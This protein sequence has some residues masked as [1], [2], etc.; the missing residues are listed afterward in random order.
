MNNNRLILGDSIEILKNIPSQS[1]DLILSDIP[2]GIGIDDWDVLHNNT[3]SA[4]GGSS[5]AQSKAGAAFKSRGKPINGWSEADRRIPFEYYEW[6]RTWAPDWNRVLKPGGSAFIFAGRRFAH[7]CIVAMEDSG[8]NFKDLLGWKRSKAL[9]RAQRLSIVFERRGDDA[10]AEEWDGWRVGNLKPT[11]E[12]I[13]WCF[14]PYRITIADNVAEHGL[15]AYN[16]QAL[17]DCFGQTDNIFECDYDSGE[18]GHHEAQKPVKL[19]RALIELTTKKGA[20]V[21]DPFAGS[22]STAAAC[23]ATGRNYVM[24]ERSPDTFRIMENRL[25]APT[26]KELL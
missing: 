21:L 2:Y 15:G 20:V 22:G 18:R 26:Q 16:Q 23:E 12:P 1:I 19:L 10:R 4:Y 11:F 8:F 7:R 6:C 14:K 24:I 13:I 9:H 17:E 3:N 25:A 5:P